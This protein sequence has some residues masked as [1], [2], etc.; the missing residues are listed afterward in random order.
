MKVFNFRGQRTG[1]SAKLTLIFAGCRVKLMA[2]I[3]NEKGEVGQGELRSLLFG[4]FIVPQASPQ[5]YIELSDLSRLASVVEEYLTDYN[6]NSKKPM[7]LVLFAFALEHVCRICRII[8]Q[9]GGHGLLVGLGGSGRQS[10]TRLA[11][12]MEDYDVRSLQHPVLLLF[13]QPIQ[14]GNMLIEFHV[15]D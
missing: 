14:S 5:L 6:N 12:F 3:A 15:F 13:N 11:A 9:P 4:D 10:L 7:H 2:R 1:K 8:R